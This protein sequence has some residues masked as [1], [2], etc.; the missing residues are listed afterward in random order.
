MEFICSGV[1]VTTKPPYNQYRDLQ[2]QGWAQR[3]AI[4]QLEIL[5]MKPIKVFRAVVICPAN[6]EIGRSIPGA[7][8]LAGE[9]RWSPAGQPSQTGRPDLQD[10]GWRLD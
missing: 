6:S 1:S 9:G 3:M 8:G 2:V 10:K 5:Q 4:K 7:G